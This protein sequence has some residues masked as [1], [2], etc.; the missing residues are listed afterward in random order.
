MTVEIDLLEHFRRVRIE[1]DEVSGE[2]A[3]GHEEAP[4]LVGV[5]VVHAGTGD[6]KR[7]VDGEGVGVDDIDA[8]EPLGHHQPELAVR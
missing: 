5:S 6:R 1:D 7:V 3:R 8:V 4:V 2:L